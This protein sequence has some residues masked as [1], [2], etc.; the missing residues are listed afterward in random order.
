MGQ[1]KARG[2]LDTSN[3]PETHP[4]HDS[5]TMNQPFLLKGICSFTYIHN[6]VKTELNFLITKI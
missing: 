4:L 2:V 1:L 6:C 3:Y 5:H